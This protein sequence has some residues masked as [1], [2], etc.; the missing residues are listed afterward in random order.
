MD[1]AG[2]EPAAETVTL[3]AVNPLGSTEIQPYLRAV[4]KLSGGTVRIDVGE[5]WHVG[6]VDS[7]KDAVEQARQG[8]VDLA[9]VPVR[10]WSDLDV[11]SF[12][13]LIAPLVVD[14]HA[15]E[16]EV[17]RASCPAECSTAL[18]S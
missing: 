6:D 7:E 9:F 5:L 11:H 4:E 3:T 13:A 18:L 16:R 8:S 15:L 14:S 10:A 2:N 12:D 17:L 1:R